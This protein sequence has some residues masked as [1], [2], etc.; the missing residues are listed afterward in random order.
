[1]IVHRSPIMNI[2]TVIHLFIASSV[3]APRYMQMVT[4]HIHFIV[5]DTRRERFLRKMFAA[6]CRE[7]KTLVRSMALNFI[8]VLEV[9]N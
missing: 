7:S 6:R 1:M 9:R 4:K 3:S 5:I 8:N 2:H